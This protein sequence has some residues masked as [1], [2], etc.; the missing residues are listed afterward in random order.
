[1]VIIC[2]SSSMELHTQMLIIC[3]A[4]MICIIIWYGMDSEFTQLH[5]LSVSHDDKFCTYS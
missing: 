4:H 5:I 1:M 2:N 3:S